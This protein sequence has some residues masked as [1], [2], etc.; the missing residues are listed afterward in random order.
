MD[1]LRAH[2]RQIYNTYRTALLNRKYYGCKLAC[3]QKY[4]FWLDVAIA[5]GA[6]G[7]SGVAGLAIW[8]TIT[9][10]FTWLVIS[11]VAT[12]LSVIK[13]ILQLGKHI[14]KYT[15]LYTGHTSIYLE[16]KAMVEDIEISRAV[17][18]KWV[19][20]YSSIR[21]LIREFAGLDDPKPDDTLIRTLQTRINEEINPADLWV[22]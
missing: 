16:L 4:N 21:L 15:K 1:V 11:G 9:G 13:P 10:K 20:R 22:P 2:L 3:Y 8:G 19:D 12:V 6:T 5:I 18:R 14:E 7:S 17:P